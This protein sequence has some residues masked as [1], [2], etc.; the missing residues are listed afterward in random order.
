ARRTLSAHPR[1]LS[2]ITVTFLENHAESLADN[3][4]QSGDRAATTAA[5]NGVTSSQAIEFTRT[6]GDIND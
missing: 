4:N 1:Q 5:R 3:N 6:L 2:V